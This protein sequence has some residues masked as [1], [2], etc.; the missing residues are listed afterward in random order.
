VTQRERAAT[1][2]EK[3]S[4]TCLF[5]DF[6]AQAFADL[7]GLFPEVLNEIGVRENI[8]L[9]EAVDGVISVCCVSK[10]TFQ[11]QDTLLYS[12]DEG[13]LN[14]QAEIYPEDFSVRT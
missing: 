5:P 11:A 4:A 14:F 3:Y 8:V 7:I 6:L 9:H 1:T 13:M 2:A 12:R 10:A